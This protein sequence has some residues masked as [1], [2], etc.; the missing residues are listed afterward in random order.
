MSIATKQLDG[1]DRLLLRAKMIAPLVMGDMLDG[2]ETLDDVAEY[3]LEDL[4]AGME[5]D[6]ALLCLA[7]CAQIIADRTM[8][9]AISHVLAAESERIITDYAPLWIAHERGDYSISNRDLRDLMILIPEDLESLG[10]LTLALCGALD[11]N[12]AI[13]AIL[14]D[15]CGAQAYM[16]MAAAE[17]LLKSLNLYD[18][19]YEEDAAPAFGGNVIAFP[20]ARETL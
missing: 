11:E 4:L 17:D 20:R 9:H 18:Y 5:P 10:D 14:C 3:A 13:A 15:I 19:D 6:G 8:D 16:H 2:R 12:E 7:L 1:R